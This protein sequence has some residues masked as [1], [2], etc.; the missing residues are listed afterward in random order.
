MQFLETEVIALTE[1]L[2]VSTLGISPQLVNDLPAN[3]SRDRTL[4]AIVNISGDWKGTVV[5]Q[6]PRSLGARRAGH[7]R[8]R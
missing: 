6:C 5:L 2:W 8:P 7:V 1:Q 4:D 3:G